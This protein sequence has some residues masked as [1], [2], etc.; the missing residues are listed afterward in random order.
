MSSPHPETRRGSHFLTNLFSR[1][2]ASLR[3]PEF[4]LA[5]GYSYLRP[6]LSD[7]TNLLKCIYTSRNKKNKYS[8]NDNK[9]GQ[10]R[11][12]FSGGDSTEQLIIQEPATETQ[13]ESPSSAASRAE[14]QQ[15]EDDEEDQN[16]DPVGGAPGWSNA[17]SQRRERH[18]HHLKQVLKNLRM[19]VRRKLGRVFRRSFATSRRGGGGDIS[20]RTG[21]HGRIHGVLTAQTGLVSFPRFEAQDEFCA[22]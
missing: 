12:A 14:Q 1:S 18:Q 5:A 2:L 10:Q 3:I 20:R 8:N 21:R 13:D 11:G 19:R 15:Q 4:S 9:N 7:T 17:N 6:S 16:N 22:E